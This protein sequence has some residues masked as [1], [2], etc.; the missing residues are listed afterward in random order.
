MKGI[1]VGLGSFGMGWCRLL[2]ALPE[3]GLLAVVDINPQCFEHTKALA[4]PCFTSL[5]E[6]IATVGKPDFIVNTTSPS[7]HLP[8]NKIAFA[9]NIPVLMEK[10][11]A[12]D[13]AQVQDMLAYGKQGQK[14]MV[15]ENYRYCLANIFVKEAIASRLK[16]IS[17]V[18][19]IYRQHHH[20][21]DTNYHTHMQ[22]PVMID[23]GVH[24]IDLLRFFTNLEVEKVYAQT[25][26][27][28]W[29]W[30]KGYSN[31]KIL[32]ELTGG[33]QLTYDTAMDARAI[34]SWFG[35]WTFTAQNGVARYEWGKLHFHMEDG[36]TTLDIPTDEKGAD[37]ARMF[38]EFTAYVKNNTPP[39]T[40]IFD[41][42]K[43]AAVVE[44]AIQS[45]QSGTAVSVD[46]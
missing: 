28:P 23:I 19:L 44:A 11:I 34:T 36:D 45:A 35:H 31:A 27:P 43:N 24:L 10:P 9:H 21:P 29:S 46:M 22:H 14:L 20:M 3:V 8:V 26:T 42:A 38:A 41:Q 17:G 39:Q 33:V 6:A 12:E 25:S 18:N 30:Y 1:H 7:G 16:N 4:I 13:F 40:H 15:A 5:E 37:K 32:G 2:A